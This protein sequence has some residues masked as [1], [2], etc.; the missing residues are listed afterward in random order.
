MA[1]VKR[2]DCVVEFGQENRQFSI[3]IFGIEGLEDDEP[4]LVE[5]LPSEAL[6]D[7]LDQSFYLGDESSLASKVA[8]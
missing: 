4:G 1:G 6:L 5:R 2:V 7:I 3:E 8:L